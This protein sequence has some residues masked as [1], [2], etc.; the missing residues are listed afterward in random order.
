MTVESVHFGG[1]VFRQLGASHR[2]PLSA[3]AVFQVAAAQNNQ[4]SKGAYFRVVCSA[5]PHKL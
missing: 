2:K 1:S 3:F 4:Y 5:T